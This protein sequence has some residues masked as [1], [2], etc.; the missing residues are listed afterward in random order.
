MHDAQLYM[1]SFELNW[2]QMTK[3]LASECM[4][5]ETDHPEDVFKYNLS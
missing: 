1:A 3:Y 5:K 4:I 2:K